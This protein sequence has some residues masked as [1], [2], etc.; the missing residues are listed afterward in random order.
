MKKKQMKWNL[1]VDE[2]HARVIKEALNVYTRAQMGQLD[3][4]LEM[5]WGKKIPAE[6]MEQ[7]RDLIKQ[8][9]DVLFPEFKNNYGASYGIASREI[10]E[11]PKIS[12]EI[13][14]TL[15][16]RISWDKAGNPQSRSWK[17]MSGVNFD[18]PMK[19]SNHPFPKIQSVN[20]KTKLEKLLGEP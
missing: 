10:G 4:I 7:A 18:D 14:K 8:L 20:I 19:F 6:N 5:F 12:Y 2:T 16:H 13:Y 1:E 15:E 17:N 3:T 11:D 9:K